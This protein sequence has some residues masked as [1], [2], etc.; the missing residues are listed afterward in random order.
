MTTPRPTCG[1]C[2]AAYGWRH[3]A[4]QTVTWPAG[5]AKPPYQGNGVVTRER[6]W[7]TAPHSSSGTVLGK[8]FGHDDNVM[9][10]DVWDGETWWGGYEPFCT[11]RC[12]LN[13]ARKAYRAG[14]RARKK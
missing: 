6:M 8:S 13:Y 10:R 5:E 9:A 11:L 2:G 3:T 12:A 7:H 4:T 14:Y 1:H